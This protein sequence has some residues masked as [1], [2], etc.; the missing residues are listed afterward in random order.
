MFPNKKS[1]TNDNE[2]EKYH[3]LELIEDLMTSR[4]GN[5]IKKLI[6]KF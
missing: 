4:I 1:W 5:I 3:P 2:Y 6:E